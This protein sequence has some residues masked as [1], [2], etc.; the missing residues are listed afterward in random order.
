MLL[1]KVFDLIRFSVPFQGVPPEQ[2]TMITTKLRRSIHYQ[3]F[4]KLFVKLF[5]KPFAMVPY[6]VFFNLLLQYKF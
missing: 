6:L 5:V 2:L 1:N 3:Q 4:V